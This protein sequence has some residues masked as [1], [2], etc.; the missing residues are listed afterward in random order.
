MVLRYAFFTIAPQVEKAFE[1]MAESGLHVIALAHARERGASEAI[2][3]NTVGNLCEGT[4]TNIVV[5]HE[6]RLVTPPLSSG[7]LAGV[8]RALVIE[9][10]DVVEADLPI[11][12]L[13][14]TGEAF[15]TS[16]TRDV[17]G[18]HRVDNR[19]LAIG[20]LTTAAAEALAALMAAD[21]DP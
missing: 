13:R 14:T 3:A 10:S 7:C 11:G 9:T 12:V 17:M 21:V 8:T 20:P 2:F 6:G 5:E 16:S 4:G 19:E 1:T 18:I 15:L